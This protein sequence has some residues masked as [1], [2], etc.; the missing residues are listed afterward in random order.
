MQL[1]YRLAS[2]QHVWM[3]AAER[4]DLRLDPIWLR[5][6]RTCCPLSGTA[7]DT[8]FVALRVSE[9]HPPGEPRSGRPARV[10]EASGS[11]AGLPPETLHREGPLALGRL[12]RPRR[13]VEQ[14]RDP[15]KRS[16]Q[17]VAQDDGERREYQPRKRKQQPSGSCDAESA[18]QAENRQQPADTDQS[19]HSAL[20]SGPD[21]RRRAVSISWSGR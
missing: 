19:S 15:E 16:P 7:S 6:V 20:T 14:E 17:A 9:H 1:S 2:L 11:R 8:E 18:H 13:Q 3:V 10:R 21:R 12:W 5:L 4:R